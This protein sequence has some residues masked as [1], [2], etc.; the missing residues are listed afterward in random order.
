MLREILK[1]RQVPDEPRRRWFASKRCDLLVWY[2]Q[3]TQPTGFQFCYTIG[4]EEKA[5]TWKAPKTFSHLGVD[6][7]EGRPY[8]Y[9][10]TPLLV[11]DG[12]FDGPFVTELFQKEAQHLPEDITELVLGKL[13]EYGDTRRKI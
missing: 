2:G 10:C 13:S 9:K 1:V 7:G 6:D 4:S 3:P 8:R 11:A 5:L 12:T